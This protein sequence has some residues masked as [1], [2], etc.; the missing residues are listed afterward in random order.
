VAAED[1]VVLHRVLPAPPEA[2]FAAWTD[3]A[4]IAR[5]MSPFGR[6]E[7]AVDLRVGG[8]FRVVMQ[9][10]DRGIEHAGEYREIDP[11]RRLVFTWRSPYT[12]PEPSLVTVELRP[13]PGDPGR[14]RFT[15]VHARL[16]PERA[17]AH[18]AGWGS[19]LEH[20]AAHLED[21]G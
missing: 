18:R 21:G 5:W 7:A 8:A 13:E 1:A 10:P 15:L 17:D 2:V 20:L 6:A 19:I 14:T 16:P 12:G 11:P 3:P 4:R 9:G